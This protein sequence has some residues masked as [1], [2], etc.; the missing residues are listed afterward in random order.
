MIGCL[1][2]FRSKGSLL[3]CEIRNIDHVRVYHG[4]SFIP[5]KTTILI[6]EKCIY[7]YVYLSI[8][9]I[10]LS[11][12]MYACMYVYKYI[13]MY[14]SICLY[15]YIYLSFYFLSP[16]RS[17]KLS[18]KKKILPIK[19]TWIYMLDGSIILLNNRCLIRPLSE[20]VIIIL[21]RFS[22]IIKNR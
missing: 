9:N 15:T 4:I 19:W 18:F 3:I 21:P 10:Y 13:C 1:A 16:K 12:C 20:K 14:L 11:V 6:I 8:S 5:S 2:R 7:S 17:W 22:P